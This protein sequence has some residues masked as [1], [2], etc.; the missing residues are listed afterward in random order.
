MLEMNPDIVC[1]IIER[2]REFHA[3][4]EVVITEEPGSPADD[5]ALQVLADHAD[6]LTYQDLK[7]QIDDLDP[8][9]QVQLVALM[10]MGRGD[11]EADEW[12]TAL[13]EAKDNWT[14]TTAEYLIATPLVADYLSEGLDMLGYSC[15]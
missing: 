3:K 2:A 5:W 14:P 12:N 1:A 9:Q 7:T 13:A 10:W 15:E 6:D 4:E 8:E 11:Y